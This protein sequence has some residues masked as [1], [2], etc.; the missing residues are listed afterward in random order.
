MLK[1][2]LL[3]VSA[4]IG[5]AVSTWACFRRGFGE[6]NPTS[7]INFLPSPLL[8][9]LIEIPV[10]ALFFYAVS[11]MKDSVSPL[12]FNLAMFALCALRFYAVVHNLTVLLRC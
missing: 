10:M 11:F 2:F 1:W 7:V 6:G 5:D 4:C 8:L 9:P 3:Y 12:A